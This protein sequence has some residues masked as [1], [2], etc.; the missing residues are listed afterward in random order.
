MNFNKFTIKSQEAIQEA[1]KVAQGYGHQ[2]IENSHILQ[3]I[4]EVD[5]NV[6]PFILKKLGINIDLLKQLITRILD[7]YAK[8]SGGDNATLS[9]NASKMI[10]IAETEA[11]NLKDEYVSIEHLLLGILKTKDTTSQLLKDQGVNEKNLKAAILELRKGS[12]VTSQSA[13]ETY[14]ALNKY[15]RNLNQLTKEGKLDPVIGR[16]EEIRRILQILLYILHRQ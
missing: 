1:Q 5:E 10:S 14:N 11:K 13:E 6:T 3:A 12:N 7:S 16:D 2:E 4:F 8:V 9:R 15:A